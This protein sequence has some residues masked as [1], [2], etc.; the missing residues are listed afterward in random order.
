[1]VILRSA[2]QIAR[3]DFLPLKPSLT[4]P[5]FT[6]KTANLS[7]K[8][9]FSV[10]RCTFQL[11]VHNFSIQDYPLF[12]PATNITFVKQHGSMGISIF[13]VV[14]KKLSFNKN[15]PLQLQTFSTIC[16]FIFNSYIWY[17][18]YLPGFLKPHETKIYFLT[19][20]VKTIAGFVETTSFCTVFLKPIVENYWFQS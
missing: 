10:S 14:S 9:T 17:F 12:K 20:L 5:L 1:M 19:I 6:E 3:G 7:K 2:F 18:R 8:I 13:M 4:S 11:I 15:T 16:S